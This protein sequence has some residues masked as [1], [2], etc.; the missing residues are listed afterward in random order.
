MTDMKLPRTWKRID[1]ICTKI[2]GDKKLEKFD[3]ILLRF[4]SLALITIVFI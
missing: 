4:L 3:I 2:L 1:Y